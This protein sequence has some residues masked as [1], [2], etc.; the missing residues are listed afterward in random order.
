[1]SN[2][3]LYVWEGVLAGIDRT[4]FIFVL[5]HDL[6]EARKTAISK[7]K[8]DKKV[9]SSVN[10]KEPKIYDSPEAIVMWGY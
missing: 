7:S 8:N 4:G 1:M 3:K 10:K 9:I 5:A 6:E 2:L